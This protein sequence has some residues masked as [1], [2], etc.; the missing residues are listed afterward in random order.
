MVGKKYF[1]FTKPQRDRE[2]VV[3]PVDFLFHLFIYK[4]HQL[5]VVIY[6]KEIYSVKFHGN[7]VIDL[8][9][10]T[11]QTIPTGFLL[12]AEQSESS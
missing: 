10:T 12:I 1:K 11:N 2:Q 8:V 4:F 7:V 9:A 5:F 6:L 3:F